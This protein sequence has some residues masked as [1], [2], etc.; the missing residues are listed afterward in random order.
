ML[1]HTHAEVVRDLQLSDGTNEAGVSVGTDSATPCKNRQNVNNRTLYAAAGD[2]VAR[3]PNTITAMSVTLRPYLSEAMP[4]SAAPARKPRKKIE[5]VTCRIQ[6][7]S[8]N[9][10]RSLRTDSCG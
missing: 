9:R 3:A 2:A 6:A 10:S 5:F 8:Q 4:A 1:I 7:L